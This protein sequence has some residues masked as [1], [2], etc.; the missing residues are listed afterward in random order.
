MNEPS[1]KLLSL[2]G[3]AQRNVGAQVDPLRHGCG[4]A[5]IGH[6]NHRLDP[7][8][9]AGILYTVKSGVADGKC[10]GAFI[11][12]VTKGDGIIAAFAAENVTCIEGRDG[13]ECFWRGGA[14]WHI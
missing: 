4:M 3:R 12:R 2:A 14:A 7:A 8:K 10:D 11:G 1:A 5:G 9:V 13:A 6:F